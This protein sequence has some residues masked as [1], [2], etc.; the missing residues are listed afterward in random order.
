MR[1]AKLGMGKSYHGLLGSALLAI[2]SV[3]YFA[4][5]PNTETLEEN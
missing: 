2:K 3:R 5:V 4:E 1:R